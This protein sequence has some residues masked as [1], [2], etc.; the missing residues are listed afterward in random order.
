MVMLNKSTLC[1]FGCH[2]HHHWLA[3]QFCSQKKCH[4]VIC[5]VYVLSILGPN[6][7]GNL[8]IRTSIKRKTWCTRRYFKHEMHGNV[9]GADIEC[10][11]FPWIALNWPRMSWS[12]P[13]SSSR[14]ERRTEQQQ[15]YQKVKKTMN[16]QTP[17][18]RPSERRIK[19][20]LSTARLEF[21]A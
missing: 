1:V 18:R 10:I 4:P 21:S 12:N 6:I 15:Q 9:S 20:R 17:C 5:P 19:C 16:I 13:I 11:W 3:I 2:R 14:N 8:I 7:N